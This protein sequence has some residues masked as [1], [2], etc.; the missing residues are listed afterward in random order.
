MK[1]KTKSNKIIKQKF[2]LKK[3][4]K[5]IKYFSKKKKNLVIHYNFKLTKLL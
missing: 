5:K 3:K 1:Y 2:K 4:S